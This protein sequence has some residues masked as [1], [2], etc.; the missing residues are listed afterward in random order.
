MM[1]STNLSAGDFSYTL[2]YAV[3]SGVAGELA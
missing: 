2:Y 3:E 1:K